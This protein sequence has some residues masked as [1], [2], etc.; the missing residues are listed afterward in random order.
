MEQILRRT[1]G[2]MALSEIGSNPLKLTIIEKKIMICWIGEQCQSWM[3]KTVCVE[4]GTVLIANH[5]F[6]RG[7]PLIYQPGFMV[8]GL[9]VP[10]SS[11]F[12]SISQHDIHDG[13]ANTPLLTIKSCIMI[14]FWFLK[15]HMSG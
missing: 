15:N 11:Q 3:N 12:N 6:L 14:L 5:H 2:P 4:V 10:H 7:I 8:P 1:Y 9:T 13:H